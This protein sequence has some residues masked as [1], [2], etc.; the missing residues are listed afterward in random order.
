MG[1]FIEKDQNKKAIIKCLENAYSKDSSKWVSQKEIFDFVR[2][3][4]IIN[5]YEC[6]LN[7]N[8]RSHDNCAMINQLVI[9]LQ[10]SPV[11]NF[12]II[13][14]NCKFKIAT[15]K[16]AKDYIIKLRKSAFNKLYRISQMMQKIRKDGYISFEEEELK[17]INVFLDHENDAFGRDDD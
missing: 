15:E 16:E 5:D 2:R 4:A 17:V 14:K 7:W 10:T 8:D 3:D 6:L 13:Q 12:I 9:E 11:P 1:K